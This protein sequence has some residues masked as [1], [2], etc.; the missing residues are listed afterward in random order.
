MQRYDRKRSCFQLRLCNKKL[1]NLN[2]TVDISKSVN[3]DRESFAFG[4]LG[5]KLKATLNP[6]PQNQ[7]LQEPH[8]VA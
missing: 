8:F 7:G 4:E 1:A 3:L 2:F 5:L 6:K